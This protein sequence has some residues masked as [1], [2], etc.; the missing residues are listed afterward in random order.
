MLIDTIAR[1]TKVLAIQYTLIRI[2]RCRPLRFRRSSS[3]IPQIERVV[4]T[5][6]RLVFFTNLRRAR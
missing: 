5:A 6:K 1:V 2:V 4:D 3:D